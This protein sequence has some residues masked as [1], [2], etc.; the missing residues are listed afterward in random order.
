[1]K[2]LSFFPLQELLKYL[3]SDS[4]YGNSRW[5][6]IDIYAWFVTH[7]RT[8]WTATKWETLCWQEKVVH[9]EPRSWNSPS[10]KPG[11]KS[12]FIVTLTQLV[13]NF[14]LTFRYRIIA[15]HSVLTSQDQSQAFDIPPQGCRK[16]VIATNIAETGITIPDVVFVIDTGKVKENR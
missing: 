8:V 16:I 2:K 14:F 11:K 13:H 10:H 1:M 15:L 9:E 5:S 4:T 12:G 7:T 3:D 6:G